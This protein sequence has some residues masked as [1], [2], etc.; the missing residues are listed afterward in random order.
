[1]LI[2]K[3]GHAQFSPTPKLQTIWGLREAI[4]FMLECM[5]VVVFICCYYLQN[6]FGMILSIITLL[7]AI[8]LLMS[9]LGRPLY[10][11]M[12]IK[13][14]RKSWI[15]RGTLAIG[16]FTSL[17]MFII[18]DILIPI[19]F[20]KY[21]FRDVIYLIIVLTGF[22]ITFYPGIAMSASAGIPFWRTKL[23]PLSSSLNGIITGLTI[24]IALNINNFEAEM[25]KNIKDTCLL[26][27]LGLSINLMFY[28]LSMENIKGA[29][30]L[31]SKYLRKNLYILFWLNGILLGIVIPFII[32]LIDS[33]Q[34]SSQ[35][36]I[37]LVICRIIGDVSLR[38]GILKAGIYESP[39]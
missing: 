15:S 28:F 14:Y 33:N 6:L 16:F 9:H 1:M 19:T 17:A 20:I 34:L 22:F 2:Q 3:Q 7:T 31:S 10:A 32:L 13:N 24:V 18:F 25:L 21:E 11:W 39:I 8:I 35:L 26:M 4:T 38:Y 27:I 37:I 5:S 29:A 36:M 12:A 23:L 30:R